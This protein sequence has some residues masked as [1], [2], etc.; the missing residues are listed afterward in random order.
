MATQEDK[1]MLVVRSNR[2]EG[3]AKN[4]AQACHWFQKAAEHGLPEGQLN[5]ARVIEVGDPGHAKE[6]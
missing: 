3:L 1:I 5:F 2:G 4:K 6:W